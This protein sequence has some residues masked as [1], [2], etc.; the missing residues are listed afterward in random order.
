MSQAPLLLCNLCGA[1]F[2]FVPGTRI[3]KDVD[4]IEPEFCPYCGRA[5][6]INAERRTSFTKIGIVD[7]PDI[8]EETVTS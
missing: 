5:N 7:I 8:S 3:G 2:Q 6:N 4:R 1:E